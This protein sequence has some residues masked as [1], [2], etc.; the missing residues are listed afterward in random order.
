MQIIDQEQ[1]WS[2]RGE[3][4]KSS[5]DSVEQPVA[6]A[7]VVN[8]AT[9]VQRIGEAGLRESLC[10]GLERRQRLFG[11]PTEEHGRAVL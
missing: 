7:R 1:K 11:A 8:R 9:G 3:I 10:V 4:S 2:A 5:V 6:R